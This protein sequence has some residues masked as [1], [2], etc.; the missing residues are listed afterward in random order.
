MEPNGIFVKIF[1]DKEEFERR[2]P[3]FETKLTKS[4]GER[5]YRDELAKAIGVPV[6]AKM[7]VSDALIDVVKAVYPF[8][9]DYESKE[10]ECWLS[11]VEKNIHNIERTIDWLAGDQIPTE[12]LEENRLAIPFFDLVERF[13]KNDEK[14]IG[15]YRILFGMKDRERYLI[16][17]WG[18]KEVYEQIQSELAELEAKR[19]NPAP[20]QEMP[21]SSGLR[22]QHLITALT[23]V[24]AIVWAFVG[25]ISYANF[26]LPNS[27]QSVSYSVDESKICATTGSL[28]GHLIEYSAVESLPAGVVENKWIPPGCPFCRKIFIRFS[29]ESVRTFWVSP[30]VFNQLK[31]GDKL[32]IKKPERKEF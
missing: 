32:P 7:K 18:P 22:K 15:K 27:A 17:Y 3:E 12:V 20:C 29:S 26:F 2:K 24:A 6:L 14:V 21:E 31:I 11:I 30:D 25:W 8:R 4:D 23:A 16:A 1:R 13:W 19:N 28:T 5:Q 10:W 9:F